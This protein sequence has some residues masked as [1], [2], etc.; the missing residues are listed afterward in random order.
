MLFLTCRLATETWL[1]FAW[2]TAKKYHPSKQ[3]LTLP[4]PPGTQGKPVILDP[5]KRLTGYCDGNANS[6]V[7][8]FK[9]LGMQVSY[10]TLFFWGIFWPFDYLPYLWLLPAYKYFGFTGE[11][12][13]HQ[14]RIYSITIGAYTTSSISWRRSLSTDSAMR[15]HL[16]PMYPGTVHI[17]GLLAHILHTM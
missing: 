15:P 8:V 5:K 7:V 9:D 12:I 14:V 4:S 10:S 3:R 2:I 1:F 17:I 16:S 11:R 6:L 13:I